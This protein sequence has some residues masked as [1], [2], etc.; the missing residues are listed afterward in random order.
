MD[1]QDVVALRFRAIEL[2]AKFSNGTDDLAE[3]TE[4]V[5]GIVFATAPDAIQ[6]IRQALIDKVAA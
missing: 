3:N 5:L 2:A 6:S 4:K 1:I